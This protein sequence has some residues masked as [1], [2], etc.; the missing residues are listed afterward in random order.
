M[1]K[2]FCAR[3]NLAE[4][5]RARREFPRAV[6]RAVEVAFNKQTHKRIKRKPRRWAIAK[7]QPRPTTRTSRENAF[8]TVA[9]SRKVKRA[10][11]E[12]SRAVLRAVGV[13]FNK[14][15]HKRIKRK[16]R[17]WQLLKSNRAPITRTTRENAFYTVATSRKVK[18]QGANFP[19]AVL[20]AVG[21]LLNEQT[22]KSANFP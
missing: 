3:G 7:K 9:T 16:L 13:T 1:G 5:K 10:R 20:S 14:Q 8:H 4:S 6:L 18:G 2:L 15:T 12:L 22:H 19:R 17:R 21:V 11:R